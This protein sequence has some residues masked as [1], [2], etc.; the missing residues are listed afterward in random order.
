MPYVEASMVKDLNPLWLSIN[1]FQEE[2]QLE[3][4]R[5]VPTCY[6]LIDACVSDF[7]VSDQGR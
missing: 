5:S 2:E 4:H 7:S 6:V 3:H 1:N